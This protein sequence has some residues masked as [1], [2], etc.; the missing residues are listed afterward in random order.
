MVFGVKGPKTL[1]ASAIAEFLA[2]FFLVDPTKIESNLLVDAKIVLNHVQ[3]RPQTTT[4]I[5]PK[6]TTT[7]K[8][9]S[10]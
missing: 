8:P 9:S 1:L 7:R 6:R 10:F 3:L 5:Q 2:E 4:R